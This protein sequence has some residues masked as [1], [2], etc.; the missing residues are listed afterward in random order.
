[1]TCPWP[2]AHCPPWGMK[3][4]CT[5]SMRVGKGPSSQRETH[6]YFSDPLLLR[7]Y[8][9]HALFWMVSYLYNDT[10]LHVGLKGG[11]SQGRVGANTLGLL[12]FLHASSADSTPVPALDSKWEPQIHPH[13]QASPCSSRPASSS[14]SQLFHCE[15]LHSFIREMLSESF[16]V[17]RTRIRHQ[18]VKNK[19]ETVCVFFESA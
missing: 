16:Q 18:N 13:S 12:D 3:E 5:E 6:S 7:C 9:T 14:A 8:A 10:W 2:A 1:M 19:L 17:S 11:L 15:S 4:L